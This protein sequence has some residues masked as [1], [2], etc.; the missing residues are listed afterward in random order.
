M[1]KHCSWC[2]KDTK[3][4]STLLVIGW[5]IYLLARK[6]HSATMER[7]FGRVALITGAS[8]VGIGADIAER[9][10]QHGMKVVGCSRNIQK[11]EV[12]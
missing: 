6:R 2:R 10:V 4:N 3:S 5:Q 1:S 8:S 11:I 7:W 12:R 9:L